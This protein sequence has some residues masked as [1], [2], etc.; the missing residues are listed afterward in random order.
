MKIIFKPIFI[1]I[2][3]ATASW[4]PF[5]HAEGLPSVKDFTVEAKESIEKQAPILV[6]FMSKSCSY[7]ETALNDFLLPMQHDPEYGN[8]VILRQIDTDSKDKLVDFNGKTTTNRAFSSKHLE[9]GV[10]TVMLFDSQGNELAS[11]VGLITVDYYLAY[12]DNAISE[13]QAKIKA[14]EKPQKL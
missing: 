8:R 7:C 4:L 9:W 13:S 10:P 12:L 11:I 6:L 5:A 14:A 3:L 1:F 2:L